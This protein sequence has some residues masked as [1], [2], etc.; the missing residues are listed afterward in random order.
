MFE[1]IDI[2]PTPVYAGQVTVPSVNYS[3]IELLNPEGSSGGG[4][5]SKSQ[6]VLASSEFSNL[7]NEI[8]AH[9]DHYYHNVL[10]FSPDTKMYMTSSW[11]TKHSHGDIAETH[12]HENSLVSGVVYLK[13]PPNSGD[14]FFKMSV[15]SERRI[16]P[17]TISPNIETNNRYNSK[18]VQ[19]LVK[20]GLI[21]L[22]PST[23][24]HSVSKNLSNDDRY[25]IAFNYFIKGKLGYVTNELII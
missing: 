4:L 3:S 8:D 5:I 2:F 12:L 25:V 11:M 24:L 21:L 22:F 18:H 17:T 14:L 1:V 10:G 6:Q 9:V 19:F 15:D 23:I 16:F 20:E 7:K 13:V